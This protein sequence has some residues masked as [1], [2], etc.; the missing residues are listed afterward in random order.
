MVVKISKVYG[1]DIYTDSGKYLG[2]VHDL[3][4]DLE[5]GEVVRLTLEPLNFL[6][7]KDEAMRI[8][9]EKSL[10]YKNVKSVSDVVIV[11]ESAI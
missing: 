5:K 1:L 8:L 3:I 2:R 7:S 11:T 9:R 10:L 4:V 6:V